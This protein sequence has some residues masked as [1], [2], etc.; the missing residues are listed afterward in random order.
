MALI[1]EQTNLC[2]RL[3]ESRHRRRRGLAQLQK[4]PQDLLDVAVDT[5]DPELKRR[6]KTAL[7]RWF[8]SAEA[9]Q[10]ANDLNREFYTVALSTVQEAV[11]IL[12]GARTRGYD[13]RGRSLSSGARTFVTTSI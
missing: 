2:R 13:P 8:A 7:D 5:D 4:S 1:D 11:S 10:Q 3:E 9:T 6:G 12:T